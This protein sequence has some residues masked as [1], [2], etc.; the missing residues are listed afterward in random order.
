LSNTDNSPLFAQKTSLLIWTFPLLTKFH[1]RSE[2]IFH[3][4]KRASF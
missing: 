3:N 1:Y 4:W 2:A